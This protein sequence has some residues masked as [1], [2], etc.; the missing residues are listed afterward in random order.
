MSDTPET[1]KVFDWFYSRNS[2][3]V[4]SFIGINR[5]QARMEDM[6]R[7]RDE[8]REALQR[9]TECDMRRSKFIARTAL[10]KH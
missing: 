5:V 7:E 1:Q 3:R 4:S 9:I 10:E 8:A 6:E 2:D